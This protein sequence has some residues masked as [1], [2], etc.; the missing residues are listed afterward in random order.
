MVRSYGPGLRYI[1]VI[2][3][4]YILSY[5]TAF[6]RRMLA[7]KFYFILFLSICIVICFNNVHIIIIGKVRQVPLSFLI[8]VLGYFIFLAIWQNH[9]NIR[10][11]TIKILTFLLL[12]TIPPF[13]HTSFNHTPLSQKIYAEFKVNS[14][15]SPFIIITL[16][17]Y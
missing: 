1:V 16:I 10:I 8:S 9:S 2:S 5:N 7:L 15:P 14:T 13:L 4:V 6:W 11:A 3:S 17:L 12:F